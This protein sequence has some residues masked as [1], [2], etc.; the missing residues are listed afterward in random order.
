MYLCYY[1]IIDKSKGKCD[2][3]SII[4]GHELYTWG[5]D[6]DALPKVHDSPRKTELLSTVDVLSLDTGLWQCR[7]TTGH[8]HPGVQGYSVATIGEKLFFFG[9]HCGHDDCYHNTLSQLDPHSLTWRV[10]RDQRDGPMKKV[11]CGMIPLTSGELFIVGGE[12]PPPNNPQ[13]NAKYHKVL[14]SDNT[15]RTNEQHL[16]NLS[17]GKL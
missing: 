2:H 3:C 1:Y 8:P 17:T 12:G 14:V 10:H 5:D 15:V 9:G 6:Q 16:Y 4:L 7:P 13:P 11:W